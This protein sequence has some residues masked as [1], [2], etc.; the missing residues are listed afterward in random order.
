MRRKR[1]EADRDAAVRSTPDHDDPGS[2]QSIKKFAA[3]MAAD[4]ATKIEE[5]SRRRQQDRA[6][7]EQD[8]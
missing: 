3:E 6:K 2:E 4:L 8:A 5:M 1:I 7:T